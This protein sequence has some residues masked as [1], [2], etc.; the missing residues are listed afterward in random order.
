MKSIL[1]IGFGNI[2][3]RYLEGILL[4]NQ[5]IEITIYDINNDQFKK[6]D[7]LLYKQKKIYPCT[8]LN[9]IKTYYD[10]C[11]IST[12]SS[13]RVSIINKI[14]QL[15]V[16]IKYWIIEKILSPNLNHLR[17]IESTNLPLS[18]YV[19]FPRRIMPLYV[20]LKKKIQ[21]L[22]YKKINIEYHAND[23]NL[24][25]NSLHFI[26]LLSWLFDCNLI[27][28]NTD[29]LKNDW[30]INRNDMYYDNYGIINC[31]FNKNIILK[32]QSNKIHNNLETNKKY[33]KSKF[34]IHLDKVN[35]NIYESDNLIKLN[36]QTI[37][38]SNFL[39]QSQLSRNI[40]NEIFDMNKC[41]LSLLNQSIKM[42]KIY[43]SALEKKWKLTK[44]IDLMIT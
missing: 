38:V 41:S 9:E 21:L 34:V 27:D 31:Y 28:I 40:V 7:K 2:G 12:T 42:H 1:I 11:I 29:H 18:T 6:I 33:V 23:W 35:I 10:I 39:L 26:D 20:E 14:N 22:D 17:A 24:I 25:S 4:S 15:N 43:L 19:N 32:L 5:N 30:F 44:F 3:Y 13:V 16:K 36:E 37:I 8:S